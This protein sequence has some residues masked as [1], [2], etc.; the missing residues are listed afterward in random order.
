MKIPF[1]ATPVTRSP[2]TVGEVPDQTTSPDPSQFS[3]VL[4]VISVLAPVPITIPAAVVRLT[5]TASS[6][7]NPAPDNSI[8]IPFVEATEHDSRLVAVVDSRCTPTEPP[9]IRQSSAFTVASSI[10]DSAVSP[11]SVIPH[12]ANSTRDPLVACTPCS[13]PPRISESASFTYAVPVK[14]TALYFERS[15]RLSVR[16]ASAA[17]EISNPFA[18][19][20]AIEQPFAV[21]R[22]WS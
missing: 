22:L 17:S 16:V 6:R 20:S 12:A 19:A 3:I 4:P 14:C 15:N 5:R 2:V 8:P 18:P 10:T 21:S 9:L 1:L 13:A 11:V 7:A